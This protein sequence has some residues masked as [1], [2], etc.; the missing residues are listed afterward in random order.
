MTE[1]ITSQELEELKAL[2]DRGCFGDYN[3]AAPALIARLELMSEALLAAE[4][5]DR[6][7]NWG[8]CPCCGYQ[9]GNGHMPDCKIGQ[10][11]KGWES[12]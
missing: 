5:A 11:L 8:Y 9:E 6:E 3:N 1:P 12:E 4:Y 2:R 10:A 7:D